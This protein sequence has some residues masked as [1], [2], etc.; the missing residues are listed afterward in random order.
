MA[1]E[2]TNKFEKTPTTTKERKRPPVVAI[3]GHVDHGKTSLLDYIRKSAVAQKEAGGITQHIGAYQIDHKGE[4]TTFIDTP[5]HEAFSQM[6][7]RGGQVSDIAVLVVAADDG[8]MPQTKESIAHIKAAG[9][10]LLVAINKID[11]PGV[12][13]DKVKNQLSKEGVNV[14]GYGGD[15]V[16][17]PVSAKTGQG[18]EDLLE[19]IDLLAQMSE[20]KET[21]D[22]PFKGVVIESRLDKF[23]G[24]VA[25][26]IVKEGVLKV[27]DKL[28]TETTSGKVRSLLD[29]LGKSVR[30]AAPS[31]P[32]EVLGFS[33]PPRVG[34]VVLQTT[35]APV[36]EK[37]EKKL[38][39]RDRI[40]EPTV[41][42]IRLIIKAD[43]AG[44][45]EAIENSIESLKKENQKVKIYFSGTG[46]ITESDVLL[47]SATRSL[48]V[49]FNVGTASGAARLAT[50]EKVLIRNFKIIYE[51]LDELREGLES[52]QEEKKEEVARGQAEVLAKFKSAEGKVAGCRVTSGKI[53]KEDTLIIK[54]GEKERGRSKIASMKHKESDIN[55]AVEGDEF[56]VILQKDLSF[57]KGDIIVAIGPYI[58]K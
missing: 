47:A 35:P 1:K 12:S 8:V 57:A 26:I 37:E 40:V 45:I 9:I 52:L 28:Y 54:S 55:E 10:P 21:Q 29:F 34:D 56:G 2:N 31:T 53:N 22:L 46:D 58:S 3:L 36:E 15:T 7:A 33:K 23:R 24:S 6:R 48:I 14:E 5:G 17:V 11:I 13:V 49:G 44:S 39:L 27:G 38:S 43:V 30:E 41:D 50:E 32:I 25:T 20:L 51:L 16:V 4:K 18:V 42:E 19:M